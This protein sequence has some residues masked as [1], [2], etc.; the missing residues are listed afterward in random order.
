MQIVF[1]ILFL[2]VTAASIPAQQTNQYFPIW[3]SEEPNITD[4]VLIY[5]GGTHRHPWTPDQLAPYVSFRPGPESSIQTEQWLFDGFLFIEFQDGR[6]HTYETGRNLKPAGKEEWRWLLDRNFEPGH[7]VPALETICRETRQRIG[8][9]IRK[10]QVILTIPEPINGQT[11]WGEIDGR[12]LYFTNAADRVAACGWFIDEAIKRWNAAGFQELELAGFYWVHE[13][14]NTARDVLPEVARLVHQ[15]KKKF[16]WIPYWGRTA[17]A[18]WRSFGFDVAWQQPNHFF[19]TNI[20]NSRITEACEFAKQHGM[21]MEMEF[22]GR[23]ISDPAAFRPR[24]HAYLEGFELSGARDN[25]SIA[26]Y[27]GGGAVLQLARSNKPAV[28]EQ[29][30]ILAKWILDRQAIADRAAKRSRTN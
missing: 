17:A 22:D 11:N 23:M 6:G 29:Y 15:Q 21:G 25:A 8:A 9:P 1:V 4:L 3:Q 2:F 28:R 10:R 30:D 5:Q 18:E 26:Y 14:A 12:P 13:N 20:P 24:F 19:N 7:G 16:F 27:E